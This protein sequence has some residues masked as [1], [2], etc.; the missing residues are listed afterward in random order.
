[1][2]IARTQRAA[3]PASH[4]RC[5]KAPTTYS[6]LHGAQK[7]QRDPPAGRGQSERECRGGK[8]RDTARREGQAGDKQAREGE[9]E[10]QPAE[11]RPAHADPVQI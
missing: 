4:A 2:D 11:G 7:P 10:A 9:P 5:K 6:M 1:M 3:K 8:S